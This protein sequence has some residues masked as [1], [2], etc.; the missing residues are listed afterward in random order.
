MLVYFYAYE[1]YVSVWIRVWIL[2][3]WIRIWLLRVCLN[4][5]CLS[6]FYEYELYK[7][8]F[9]RAACWS[10]T[11]MNSSSASNVMIMQGLS[12]PC[13]PVTAMHTLL[14]IHCYAYTA[15]HTLLRIHCYAHPATHTLQCHC[16][17]YPAVWP[18]SHIAGILCGRT[19][20][21]RS[22]HHVTPAMKWNL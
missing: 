19:S 17:A 9:V 2:R 21:G 22:D 15:M 6:E 7:S 10:T 3:V 11:W 12:L 16:Y 20:Q 13:N 1:C 4:S 18:I 8:L 14:R 5:A